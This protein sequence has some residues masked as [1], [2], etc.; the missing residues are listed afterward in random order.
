MGPFLST[1]T[2][3]L[4]IPVVWH[5]SC[6]S[7]KVVFACFNID[8]YFM[9][10]ISIH[11]SGHATE[12]PPPFI[13]FFFINAKKRFYVNNGVRGLVVRRLVILF[14]YHGS[15]SGFNYRARPGLTIGKF[16]THRTFNTNLLRPHHKN[17]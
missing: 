1:S 9:M 17:F 15:N 11:K 6:T 13:F 7:A 14:I 4:S 8:G 5:Q 12:I 3:V 10:R 16:Q 2:L